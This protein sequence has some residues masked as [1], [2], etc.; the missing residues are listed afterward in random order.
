M[1]AQTLGLLFE[2]RQHAQLEGMSDPALGWHWR[3]PEELDAIQQAA[4]GLG[5][6]VLRLGSPED[7]AACP[8]PAQGVDLILNLAVGFGTRWR[9]MRGAALAGLLRKPWAGADPYGKL[10]SQNKHLTKALWEHLKLPTPAWRLLMDPSSLDDADLP[11]FPLLVKPAH[12]GSSVGIHASGICHDTASVRMAVERTYAPL[13]MPLL[14]EQ[15]IEGRELKVGFLGNHS[16][17]FVGV[18]EDVQK[19]GS[20]LGR[21]IMG[22][23]EKTRLAFSKRAL[24]KDDA[25]VKPWLALALQAHQL[26]APADWGTLDLRL[27]SLGQAWFLEYNADATLHPARTLAQCC[28]LHGLA[29]PKM[30]S[31]ILESAL[32]RWGLK[33]P[34]AN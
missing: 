13:Q 11:P 19:D 12:E 28:A 1:K 6:E 17:G 23:E 3:E 32:Q 27:D 25:C 29:Y 10:L 33:G 24:A 15:F 16:P 5:W 20:P 9:T 18:L 4:E 14:V 21:Q 8:A 22:L 31:M 26:H 7:A 2:T 34:Q 30:L